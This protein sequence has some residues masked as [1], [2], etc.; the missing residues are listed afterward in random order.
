MADQGLNVEL[1][2]NSSFSGYFHLLLHENLFSKIATKE[3]KY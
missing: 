2:D 3:N 1:P